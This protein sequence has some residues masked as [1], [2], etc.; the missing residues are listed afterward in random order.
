MSLAHLAV[1]PHPLDARLKCLTR[2]QVQQLVATHR[3]TLPESSGLPLQPDPSAL[4]TPTS[5]MRASVLSSV[6]S[7]V[8]APITDLTKQL[9]SLQAQVASL[10]DQLTLLTEQLQKEQEGRTSVAK[11]FEDKSQ[12]SSQDM[13]QEFSQ[14]KSQVSSQDMSQEFSQDMSQHYNRTCLERACLKELLKKNCSAY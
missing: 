13:S 9:S 4:S 5:G 14:D 6:V 3:R 2:E 11:R 1:Q 7:D 10:Q 8:S 12:V